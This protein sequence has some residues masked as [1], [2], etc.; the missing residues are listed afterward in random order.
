MQLKTFLA[1][2]CGCAL[3]GAAVFAQ[4]G[5]KLSNGDKKFLELAADANMTEAHIGQM[6]ENTAA[7]TS[8]RDFGQKLARD[9]TN[10]YAE[11]A[12]LANKIGATVPKGIDVRRDSAIRELTREKG[13]AFDRRF[14]RD[15]ILDHERALTEF[16]REAAH[17][18]D[19][20]IKAYASKMI[21]TLEEH[22]HIAESL[23]KPE[24]HSS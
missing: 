4:T 12:A 6:A 2:I 24:R 20:D 11:L 14:L 15:E 8:V 7:K 1:G 5:N 19:A 9:H 22:L 18:R 21:P 10:A 16:R 23:V 3:F 13:R 17:G